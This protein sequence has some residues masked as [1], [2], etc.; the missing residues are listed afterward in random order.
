M[1][2]SLPLTK[3][4]LQVEIFNLGNRGTQSISRGGRDLVHKQ[5]FIRLF[6]R[7]YDLDNIFQ[8]KKLMEYFL[9]LIYSKEI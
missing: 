4:R 5:D 9:S 1:R 3:S 2:P 8:F 7:V 6:Y